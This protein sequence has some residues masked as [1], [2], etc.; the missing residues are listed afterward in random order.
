VIFGVILLVAAAGGVAG[1]KLLIIRYDTAVHKAALLDP[2][3]RDQTVTN[4]GG[5]VTDA[6]HGPLN[7][8][9]LGSDARDTIPGMG[10]RSDTIIVVHIPRSMDRAYLISVPRDLRVAIPADRS[11][12]FRGSTEKINA[13]FNYGGGGTGGFRLL[14]RTLTSLIGIRFD[15]A[16]I[17]DFD[18]F[19]RVVQLLGGV[20]MCID[21]TTRSI[22]TGTVYRKGCGLLKPWQALD[23]VRQR[24]TLPGGDFDRQ[25]HQQQFLKALFTEAEKQGIATNPI[26]LDKILRAV[27]SSLTVDTNGV[28]LE[29]LVLSLR[30]VK[31]SGLVGVR[32]PSYPQMLGGTSFVL[33]YRSKVTALYRAIAD[34]SLDRWVNANATWVNKLG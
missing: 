2:D 25:R 14:S 20:H 15:G 19:R 22:H 1:I 3:A 33:P 8:L 17:I 9:L 30:S 12:H 32:L 10:Q 23:Y 21:E 26:K 24:E 6:M 34:D 18:G 13:A 27:G 31:P 4:A 7:Y 28:P 5:L 29:R 11:L 16:A